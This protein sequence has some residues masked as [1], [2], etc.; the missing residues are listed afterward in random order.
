MVLLIAGGSGG[1]VFPAI[2]FA[3]RLVDMSYPVYFLTDQRGA[4]FI[5]EYSYLFEHV[6]VIPNVASAWR[7][8]AYVKLFVAAIE[9]YLSLRKTRKFFQQY[10]VQAIFSFGGFMTVMPMIWARLWRTYG[11]KRVKFFALHQSD[12]VLGRAN[13]FL[14]RWIP[15]VFTGYP[16]T[17][18]FLKKVHPIVVGTPV[19]KTFFQIPPMKLPETTLGILI[20]GGS[21]GAS[22]WSSLI[23]NALAQLSLQHRSRLHVFHQ[24]PE[25]ELSIVKKNYGEL[26]IVCEVRP[27]FS[28]LPEVLAQVH[29]VFSRCGA[30][31]AAE[32]ACCG[33]SGFFVPYPHAKDHHQSHN[34]EFWVSQN[35][36]WSCHQRMLKEEKITLFLQECL[37]DP[38]R[39][40]YTGAHAMRLGRKDAAVAMINYWKGCV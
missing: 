3:Q 26:S 28:S 29:V 40:L 10:S 4:R 35:A 20:L 38:K 24:C 15:V 5:Q 16:D 1:H 27:F 6:E 11:K 13:R 7:G 31:T 23:L 30:S 32:L 22:F 17:L 33:R 36:G 37:E 8:M 18:G 14:S 19:R 12:R 9:M 39:L 34:A 2:A 21:Q 25:Q